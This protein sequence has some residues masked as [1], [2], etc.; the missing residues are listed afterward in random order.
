MI[1]AMTARFFPQTR[2][3][4]P[5]APA[6]RN[7]G[8]AA[9]VGAA[10]A[11]A[12]LFLAP[13]AHAHHILGIPH[14]AYDESYPQA[15][16]ITYRT[17]AGKYEVRMTGYP[18][19][20]VPGQRTTLHVYISHRSGG[21]AFTEPVTLRV[22]RDGWRKKGETVYGPVTAE[23]SE[24]LYKFYPT[25]DRE[26]N[27]LVRIDFSIDGVPWTIDLPMVVGEPGSP[28]A[29]IGGFAGGVVFL[30]I[31]VR[32]VRIKQGRRRRAEA[33]ARASSRLIPP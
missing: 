18:G 29:V 20:P 11:L 24:S 17:D 9:L 2:C 10:S 7:L 26:D 16:V 14:Y 22:L 12:V 19:H 27:F 4:A 3:F 21:P 25:F 1:G 30:L 13:G 8:S 33:A 31:V 6:A 32:A 28:L 5:R 15:P 23:L